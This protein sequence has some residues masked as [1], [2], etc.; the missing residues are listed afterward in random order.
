VAAIINPSEIRA[1]PA[2][3]A[4]ASAKLASTMAMPYALDHAPSA[5]QMTVHAKT[6]AGAAIRPR[7]I[8]SFDTA[9]SGAGPSRRVENASG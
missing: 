5:P 4:A 2:M 9:T 8:M 6:S 3:S 1:A 7:L